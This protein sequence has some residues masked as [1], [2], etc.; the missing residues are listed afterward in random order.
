MTQ[1]VLEA[2]KVE[3]QESRSQA[4]RALEQAKANVHACDGALAVLDDLLHALAS[5][6]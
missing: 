1:A 3:V 5:E 4:L 2:K 6:S